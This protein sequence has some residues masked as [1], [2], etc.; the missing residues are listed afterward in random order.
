MCNNI[1]YCMVNRTYFQSNNTNIIVFTLK[2][3]IIHQRASLGTAIATKRP[4]SENPVKVGNTRWW[5]VACDLT[6]DS[7]MHVLKENKNPAVISHT[8]EKCAILS[9]F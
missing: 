1:Q 8:R 9:R 7:H 2:F 6:F 5:L 3:R 4:F